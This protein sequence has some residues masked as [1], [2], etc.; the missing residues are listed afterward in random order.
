MSRADVEAD[1]PLLAGRRYEL[2]DED[3]NYNCLAYVL[4]DL[5]HWW[6][7]PKGSGRY[8]PEGFSSDVSVATAESI[9]RAHG[10]TVEI[11]E[12]REPQAPAI[13]IYALSDEWTH[14]AMF[15]NGSWSSKLGEGHDVARVRLEDLEGALYGKVV[16]VLGRPESTP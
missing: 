14:F 10:F 12:G 4:G 2:S 1:F 5:T 15:E 13:A 6:E 11:D 8:W 7:P 9:L 3:F 16:K